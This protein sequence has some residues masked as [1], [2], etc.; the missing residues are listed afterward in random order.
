MSE[1]KTSFD[2][3]ADPAF[4]KG[5]KIFERVG[6]VFMALVIVA[7][8]L[9]LFGKGYLSEAVLDREQFQMKYQRFLH[10]GDLTSLEIEIPP[11][12]SESGVV[13][14]AFSNAYMHNFRIERIQPDPESSA[15]GDQILYWFTATRTGEPVKVQFRLEPQTIGT[16]EGEIFVNGEDGYIFRQFV[17]P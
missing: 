14:I 16:L 3:L 2:F 12:R 1:N 4:L 6:W 17:Y 7:A 15:H 10:F 13:A 11:Q 5:E 8:M 9:G